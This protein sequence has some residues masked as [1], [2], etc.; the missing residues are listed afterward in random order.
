MRGAD[1]V[2]F[3]ESLPRQF[4]VGKTGLVLVTVQ[5]APPL[6]L[7]AIFGF[8]KSR[9]KHNNDSGYNSN[10]SLSRRT[11]QLCL[12]CHYHCHLYYMDVYQKTVS[13]VNYCTV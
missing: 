11:S 5:G 8:I 1:G 4:V 10:L 7:F 9:A 2:S 13:V 12:A 6:K 3:V